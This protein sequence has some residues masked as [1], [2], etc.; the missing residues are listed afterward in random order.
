MDRGRGDAAP[1]QPVVLVEAVVLGGDQRGHHIGRDLR[2]R[3]PVAVGPLEHRQLLA[4]G[5]QH[6]GRL[7]GLG[8]ADIADARRER[9]QDQHIEQEGRRDG[10]Q[11]HQHAAPRGA[12]R[13]GPG[14][15]G[16][17]KARGHA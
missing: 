5:G 4:V 1:V 11:A 16:A 15:A 7:L 13:P 14:Q 8:L 17:C 12:Q 3:H 10:G 6:L 9:D 2:Q